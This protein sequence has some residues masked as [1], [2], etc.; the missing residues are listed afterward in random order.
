[1]LFRSITIHTELVFPGD[2]YTVYNAEGMSILKGIITENLSTVNIG[3][4]SGG[5]YLVVV[6]NGDRL[7]REKII[8]L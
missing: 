4:L 3:H 1:M 6:Q 2:S 5:I 8:K 7:I